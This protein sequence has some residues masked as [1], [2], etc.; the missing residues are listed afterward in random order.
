MQSAVA[1]RIN[2]PYQALNTMPITYPITLP[3][4][5]VSM[6]I[7]FVGENVVG[8]WVSP[9]SLQ[10]Q[11]YEFPGKRWRCNIKVPPLKTVDAAERVVGAFLSL[12]GRLGSFYLNDTSKRVASGVAT[13]APQVSGIQTAGSMD[14]NTKGWTP[15][16]NQILKAG[17]WVQVGIGASMRLHKVLADANSNGTGNA[18]LSVWP[19]LRSAYADG[20]LIITTNASGVFTM[21]NDFTWSIDLARTYGIAIAATEL[22]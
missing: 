16:V 18:T 6:E 10:S 7:S 13:G 11:F 3:T 15:G 14:L 21:D 8:V 17:D 1:G 2:K 9:Q 19:R 5:F 4:D 20:T 22:V 12:N